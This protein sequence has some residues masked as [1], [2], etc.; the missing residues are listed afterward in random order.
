MLA[1]LGGLVGMVAAQSEEL[2]RLDGESAVVIV[3]GTSRLEDCTL[4]F[5]G[6]YSE[7]PGVDRWRDITGECTVTA[8]DPRVSGTN[9]FV[10]SQ[11]MW[12]PAGAS[13]RWGTATLDGPDGGW[14]C[15]YTSINPQDPS[16][17]TVDINLN[18]CAGTGDYD[19]LTYVFYVTGLMEPSLEDPNTVGFIYPGDPPPPWGPPLPAT[20]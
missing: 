14:D 2:E 20:E 15:S 1:M 18:V 19:G 6:R 7:E 8:S 13:M 9:S 12:S 10:E 16:T 3:T 11:D 5:W 4:T 17:P